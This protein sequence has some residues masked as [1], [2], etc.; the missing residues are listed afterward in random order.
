MLSFFVTVLSSGVPGI[1]LE[2]VLLPS[3]MLA[4]PVVP[5]VLV[6]DCGVP[7]TLLGVSQEAK[8]KTTIAEYRT[9]FIINYFK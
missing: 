6:A 5:E 4:D 9:L 1:I 2:S 7:I 3:V 8:T